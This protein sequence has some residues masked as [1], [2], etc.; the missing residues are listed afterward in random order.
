MAKRQ[1]FEYP[2]EILWYSRDIDWYL[3]NDPYGLNKD[4]CSR[5]IKESADNK[6][7]L[8]QL[9]NDSYRVA[10]AIAARGFN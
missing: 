8:E 9:L 5:Y 6:L 10:V 2:G 4:I 3:E 1:I 7:H